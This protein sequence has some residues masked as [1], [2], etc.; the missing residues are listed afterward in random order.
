MFESTLPS[1]WK[2]YSSLKQIIQ[3]V[4]RYIDLFA[5]NLKLIRVTFILMK[6]SNTWKKLK[7]DFFKFLIN[8]FLKIILLIVIIYFLVKMYYS[9]FKKWAKLSQHVVKG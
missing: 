7:S 8:Y 9:R 5:S 6:I 4:S 1:Q 3:I 2:K